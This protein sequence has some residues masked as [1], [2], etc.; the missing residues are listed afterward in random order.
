MMHQFDRPC[1]PLRPNRAPA[2]FSGHAPR[3]KQAMPESRPKTKEVQ[4][5]GDNDQSRPRSKSKSPSPH[6]GFC[7]ELEVDGDADLDDTPD[8]EAIRISARIK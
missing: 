5:P 1:P 6:A 3:L 8:L 4:V 7:P 2:S